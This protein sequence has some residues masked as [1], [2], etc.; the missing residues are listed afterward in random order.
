[1][2]QD[3]PSIPCQSTTTKIRPTDRVELR[4]MP[5]EAIGRL[6]WIAGWM[7]S[8]FQIPG[9]SRNVGLDTIIGMIP[10]VG[11]AITGIISAEFVRQAFVHGA[12]KRTILKMAMNIAVDTVVGS[13]PLLGDLFDFAFKANSKNVRLL[14]KEF[15]IRKIEK[16]EEKEDSQT[17]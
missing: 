12:R 10:G 4:V 16:I 13:V 15:E 11:D 1:M 5:E 14:E 9:T 6:K 2:I 3:S 17:N 7:D 8:A